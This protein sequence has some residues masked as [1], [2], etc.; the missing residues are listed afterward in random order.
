[1][2]AVNADESAKEKV[3]T[4]QRAVMLIIEKEPMEK[5]ITSKEKSMNSLSNSDDCGCWH[6]RGGNV[7]DFS[8]MC[9]VLSFGDEQKEKKT[10]LAEQEVVKETQEN[11]NTIFF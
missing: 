8:L 3:T 11:K 6:S 1:M 10:E 4:T 5:S 2:Y 7:E 9:F